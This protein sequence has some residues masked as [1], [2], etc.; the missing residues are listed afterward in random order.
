MN[1][2]NWLVKSIALLS[3]LVAPTVL[4]Q[5]DLSLSPDITINLDG[6]VVADEAVGLAP[7]PGAT[8]LINLGPLPESADVVAYHRQSPTESLFALD[9]TVLLGG[10][11]Y[12]PGDVIAWNGSTHSLAFDAASSGVPPGFVADAVG[13]DVLGNILLSLDHTADLG[14]GVIAA[15]EDVIRFVGT[16]PSIAFD[17]SAAGLAGALDVDGL[18]DLGVGRFALSFDTG[19]MI[20]G[21]AFADEDLLYVDATTGT[22]YLLVDGSELDADLVA[23]DVDGFA[24]PEPGMGASLMCA[25]ALMG[26]LGRRRRRRARRLAAS[27]WGARARLNASVA[28]IAS[29]VLLLTAFAVQAGDGVLEINQTCASET[30]CF[31][32]DTAGFPVTIDG[33]AG[34]SYRLSSDLVIATDVNGIEISSSYVTLDLGGFEIAGPGS[35][36]GTSTTLSCGGLGSGVGVVGFNVLYGV[37]VRNG[38]IRN[39]RLDGI[40][41]GGTGSLGIRLEGITARHNARI[42]ISGQDG[43]LAHHC[44]SVENGA[45]GFDLDAGSVIESSIAI[46]NFG[47]GVEIDDVGGVVS[48][49]TSR[50]NGG[51]GFNVAALSK[52]GVGNVSEGNGAE[53]SCGG[54]FCSERK[55]YYVGGSFRYGVDSLVGFCDSGFRLLTRQELVDGHLSRYAG[56]LSDISVAIGDSQTRF[57]LSDGGGRNFGMFECEDAN[58]IYGTEPGFRCRHREVVE[59]TSGWHLL[60]PPQTGVI[61]KT[62]CVEE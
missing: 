29:L 58:D 36:T 11:V 52:F 15:D 49:T 51:R 43:V 41:V 5:T 14:G 37:T 42:G 44:I 3:W 22:W 25:G 28:S 26:L 40:G 60:Q 61:S 4:A 46:G 30:G 6:T 10:N 53:D 45:R 62:I 56:T 17:G 47:H 33:S 7:N 55:R 12:A 57:E 23:A 31:A 2:S 54:R 27:I 38:I 24:V 19:G 59:L 13:R 34:K 9:T 20:G 48:G 35:C 21:V 1:T 18:H 16:T 50:S 32:G 8:S 39:M